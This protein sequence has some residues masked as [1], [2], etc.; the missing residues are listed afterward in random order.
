MPEGCQVAAPQA[1]SA[2]VVQPPVFPPVQLEVRTPVPPTAF[3]SAGR[4]YLVYEL[5]LRN[6]TDEPLA[7]YGLD[8]IADGHV[9]QALRGAALKRVLQLAGPRQ[10]GLQLGGGQ[11][12][13]ALLCLAFQDTPVPARLGHRM[14]LGGA[15]ADGPVL[16][17]DSAV[18]PVLGPPLEGE[19]WTADNGPSLQSHHRSGVFVAGG[20]AQL[21]RR[22]ALDWKQYRDGASYSGDARDVRSYHAYGKTVL[23]VADGVV[24]AA[25]DG[26]PDNIPRT[27]A[28]FTPAVP[29]TMDNLAGNFIVIDLG[30]GR[31]AQYAHLQPG[32]V[33]VQAGQRVRRGQAMARA[34]NSGDARQP[35][36]HFQVAST[37][38]F[39]ASEGLPYVI[40]RFRI[41]VAPGKW[42]QRSREF[43]LDGSVIDFSQ[44]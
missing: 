3:R 38:D 20:L 26:M 42:E 33:L 35:H 15:Y 34:G 37:P 39:M 4:S 7:L 32:S 10:A 9:I 17:V 31:Y 22:F 12:A 29:P 14:L 41:Q 19:G 23:A 25:R 18:P 43:P 44:P 8:V 28:G 40:E 6:F 1:P 21:S 11:G 27:P 13:V 36:L 30:Q 2:D 16:V 24:V 5:H